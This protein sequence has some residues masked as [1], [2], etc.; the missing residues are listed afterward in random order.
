MNM[1]MGYPELSYM[2]ALLVATGATTILLR[3]FPFLA[4]GT[5]KTPPRAVVELG[6]LISPA[7]IAM[8]VVYCFCCCFNNVSFLEKACGSAELIAGAVVVILQL[9]KKNPLLSI[10]AGTGIY[11]VLI[12]NVF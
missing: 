11:M 2:I 1:E 7:A 6:R 8:L 4:F 10:I 5:V 3:A 12:Q 9:L